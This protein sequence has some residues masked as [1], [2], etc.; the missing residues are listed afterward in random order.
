MRVFVYIARSTDEAAASGYS[1]RGEKTGVSTI[2]PSLN[3]CGALQSHVGSWARV[4]MN[5]C[6]VFWHKI[7]AESKQRH[8]IP[9]MFVGSSAC[10]SP[11]TAASLPNLR[12]ERHFYSLE[13]DVTAERMT[14]SSW[15]SAASG[16]SASNQIWEK[17][18]KDSRIEVFVRGL[19]FA[20]WSFFFQG[21]V[22]G[23]NYHF[24]GPGRVRGSFWVLATP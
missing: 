1:P 2:R 16:H 3:R 24:F 18:T 7:N 22:D 10:A 19:P 11:T 15:D 8:Y 23:L 9:I 20:S 4:H 6:F 21:R 14:N 5:I 12:F 17:G 13:N